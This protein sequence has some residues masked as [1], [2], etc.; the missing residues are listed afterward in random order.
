MNKTEDRVL[1]LE[2]KVKYLN[3]TN[4]EYEERK[5]AHKEHTGNVGHHEMFKP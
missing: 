1:G 3:Q 2:D 5:E 4:K